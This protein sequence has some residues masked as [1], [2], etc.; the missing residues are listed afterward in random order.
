MTRE[1]LDTLW[2]RSVN[3]S[4]K[5]GDSYARYRYAEYVAKAALTE[6]EHIHTCP[7]DCQKP[8]CVNRRREIAAAVEAEREAICPIVYGLCISDNN[9]QEIVNAIRARGS[10]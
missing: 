9:A 2:N 5:A 8:L 6:P 3:E 1:E 4:I 7:P 10:K